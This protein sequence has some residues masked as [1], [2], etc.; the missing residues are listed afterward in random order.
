MKNLT[1]T[2]A[3]NEPLVIGSAFGLEEGE[4][5][6]LIDGAFGVYMVKVTKKE[7][8]VVL[9][10]YQAAANRVEQQK[11]NVVNTKLY[12]ALKNAAE[13]EDNRAKNQIQ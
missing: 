6:G 8:A 2:G 3:G 4:T 13:I 12:D 10:N 5:S 7:P 9:D 11:V 1:L